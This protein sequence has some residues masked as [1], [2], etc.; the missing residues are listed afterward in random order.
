VR[1]E[2]DSSG[3]NIS[4]DCK[5]WGWGESQGE[6]DDASADGFEEWKVAAC[7]GVGYALRAAGVSSCDVVVTR[8]LGR[9]VVDTNPTIVAA[10]A[11]NATWN[12]LGA[13]PTAE[14]TAFVEQQV[15]ASWSSPNADSNVPNW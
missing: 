6:M 9:S 1:I 3:L 2:P 15:F 8:I 12:A 11:A 14:S 7:V 10:A 4:T 13:T 5:G